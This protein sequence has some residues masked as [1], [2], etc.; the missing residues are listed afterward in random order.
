MA[1][2]NVK[3]HRG[4]DWRYVEMRTGWEA[5]GKNAYFILSYL[6]IYFIQ[7]IFQLLMNAPALF[8]SIWSTEGIV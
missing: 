8:L 2:Y 3:R 1:V 5:K 6:M 7:S 4:E